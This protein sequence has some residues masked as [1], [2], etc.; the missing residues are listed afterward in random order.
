ML[1]KFV[2]VVAVACLFTVRIPLAQP[3]GVN[4]LACHIDVPCGIA[5][6]AFIGNLTIHQVFWPVTWTLT[7]LGGDPT[8]SNSGYFAVS[9][10]TGQI[11]TT[12]AATVPR[13]TTYT[14]QVWKVDGTDAS[15]SK[16]LVS[17]YLIIKWPGHC[18][19]ATG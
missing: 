1:L 17:A 18:N 19:G 7:Y 12:T 2:A 11:T 14:Q 3:F 16:N 8:D 6:N 5:D 9:T 13:P 4:F 10:T 15:G